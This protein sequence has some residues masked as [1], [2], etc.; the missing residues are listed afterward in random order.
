MTL[1]THPVPYSIGVKAASSTAAMAGDAGRLVGEYEQ[2]PLRQQTSYLPISA[3]GGAQFVLKPPRIYKTKSSKLKFMMSGPGATS[4]LPLAPT[5]QFPDVIQTNGVDVD[6]VT[7]GIE[8]VVEPRPFRPHPDDVLI[9]I[10]QEEE[11]VAASVAA[12]TIA[13]PDEALGDGAP[14]QEGRLT[15]DDAGGIP[16]ESNDSDVGGITA[17]LSLG[18]PTDFMN[19]ETNTFAAPARPSRK[20]KKYPCD[21]CGQIFTRSGD[22]KRHKESRHRES[23][24]CICPYCGRILTRYSGFFSLRFLWCVLLSFQRIDRMHCSVIGTNTAVKSL[25]ERTA[26]GVL[27]YPSILESTLTLCFSIPHLDIRTWRRVN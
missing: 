3:V 8:S 25:S 13:E 20:L 2:H 5:S 27:V 1:T 11:N 17:V 4:V 19:S 16:K 14:R 22:V 24:G 26:V 23:A 9:E 10:K 12:I 6:F 7:S 15:V 21:I 18:S